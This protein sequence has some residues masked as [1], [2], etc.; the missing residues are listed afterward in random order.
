MNPKCLSLERNINKW[1]K[2]EKQSFDCA[3][4]KAASRYDM[5]LGQPASPLQ[6]QRLHS[7]RYE[8]QIAVIKC[9]NTTWEG[10]NSWTLWSQSHPDKQRQEWGRRGREKNGRET[11][12]GELH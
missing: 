1:K 2:E 11:E 5:R 12:L 9:W 6:T 3:A 8:V 7:V 4:F 10:S